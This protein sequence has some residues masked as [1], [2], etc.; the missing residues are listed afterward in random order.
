MAIIANIS[1]NLAAKMGMAADG[2]DFSAKMLAHIEASEK[3]VGDLTAALEAA[4]K[5]FTAF[6]ARLATLEGK[7]ASTLTEDKVKELS[8]AQA[9]AVI[10]EVYG[11]AG[12]API[13]AAP[14]EGVTSAKGNVETL[15]AEG[16]YAE[17][18]AAS[19]GIQAEFGTV[20]TYTA[21]CK[22]DALGRVKISN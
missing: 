3:T 5:D 10:A 19:P 2:S 1:K 16:K 13:A 18:F 8:K 12:A 17:A 15:V 9:S 14:A 6:E 4:G 20:E 22:H 11:K 7:P 21:F